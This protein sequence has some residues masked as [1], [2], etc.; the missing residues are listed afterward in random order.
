MRV[1][2]SEQQLCPCYKGRQDFQKLVEL[3]D[4]S[5]AIYCYRIHTEDVHP[6]SRQGESVECTENTSR[7]VFILQNKNDTRI[8]IS[9][10]TSKL[11]KNNISCPRCR[12]TFD[13]A[14]KLMQ[15]VKSIERNIVIGICDHC[16]KK[17]Q[18]IKNQFCSC[19]EIVRKFKTVKRGQQENIKNQ[20]KTWL[21]QMEH[22]LKRAKT[23][24][25]PKQIIDR[26][27]SDL[28]IN[29]DLKSSTSRYEPKIQ[30]MFG[31]DTHTSDINLNREMRETVLKED[32]FKQGLTY[33]R[34]TTSIK[35]V[36]PQERENMNTVISH[37]LL[38]E[39]SEDV[40][41]H[42]RTSLKED[43][44]K[45]EIFEDTPSMDAKDAL[46][47]RHD[48]SLRQMMRFENNSG[49]PLNVPK[50]SMIYESPK[51][52]LGAQLSG[53]SINIK[54]DSPSGIKVSQ[55]KIIKKNK[56]EISA[57]EKETKMKTDKR[58]ESKG[59]ETEEKRKE[60]EEKRKETEE[61][62]K[63]MGEKR[64]ETEE[65]RKET[66]ELRKKSEELG[67]KSE[68]KQKETEEK[69]KK[70]EEKRKDSE[71][72]Q[73]EIGEKRKG[74]VEKRKGSEE[75]RRISE[76]KL[77]ETEEKQKETEEKRKKAEEK[78]KKFEENLKKSEEKLKKSEEKLKVT[79]EKRKEKE[80]KLK[81]KED[82][83]RLILSENLKKEKEALKQQKPHE[84]LLQKEQL[85]K[86]KEI[87]KKQSETIHKQTEKDPEFK[88]SDALSKTKKSSDKTKQSPEVTKVSLI[89]EKIPDEK[90]IA[91][92]KQTPPEKEGKS[93]EKKLKQ[94]AEILKLQAEHLMKKVSEQKKQQQLEAKEKEKRKQKEQDE[95][96]AKK[97]SD[98]KMTDIKVIDADQKDFSKLVQF[99]QASAF[100]RPDMK[101]VVTP[102][103]TCHH[104]KGLSCP[105][106]YNYELELKPSLDSTKSEPSESTED[107][108]VG[109]KK[110]NSLDIK[111]SEPIEEMIVGE[112]ILKIK[113]RLE[114]S[115]EP[116][117]VLNIYQN[118]LLDPLDELNPQK[119][120][121]DETRKQS[122]TVIKNKITGEIDLE[123]SK[124]IL[125]YR[126]SDRTFIEKGW[127]VL[128]T[129]KVVRKLNV[130]RMRPARPEFDW[131]EHNKN[132]RQM[133][134][135]TGE[136]LAEF[137][138][139]GRGRWYYRSGR[140]AL[141]YY[142]AEETNA[143]QRFVVYS[144]GEPDER[145]RT[146]PI[147]V[148]A[149]FDYLGNGV[150]FDH[151]GKIRLK[152]NQTEGVV[153]DRSIGPVSHWK[154]HT[155]NDPPVLQQVMI[156][157]QLPQ[158]DPDILKLGQTEKT[159]DK[160]D[161]EDML[162]IEF[163]NFI[164]EKSKKLTQKFK[165]F[166]IK[167]KF[168]KINEH[169]SLKVLDQA[170]VYL[171]YR[172]GST[173]LKLN[174]GMILD[175]KEIVDTETAEV[176]EVLN[177]IEQFPAR[178]DSLAGLQRSVAHAQRYERQ[179][180]ERERRI[181]PA[182]PCASADLLTAAVSAPLR[183]PFR[184][185]PS[186]STSTT[187]HCRRKPTKN[188]YYDS[189]LL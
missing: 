30:Q 101:P 140:L 111:K 150:V 119:E 53:R 17:A 136:R 20:V 85:Q 179:H 131:F 99:K 28:Q 65:K 93:D 92:I 12:K 72:K 186:G 132:K 40:K 14:Q 47:R 29:R 63:E 142:D 23:L 31:S 125:R 181:R 78:L 86:E 57:N 164:K 4:P 27:Y 113:P 1:S 48:L 32:Y 5:L 183:V 73:K 79:E 180:A 156:D 94:E 91:K 100:N 160:P 83:E 76:E 128:P 95:M 89:Q 107:M 189:R 158:K 143:K 81:E 21:S 141:D 67:K 39:I 159:V 146:H 127:T 84:K 87:P 9:E 60:T 130:Y 68:E 188:L 114:K 139:N 123:A 133:T 38:L 77:K 51:I 163:D 168:L 25:K 49:G 108:L 74:T 161:N 97:R 56:K 42:P 13:H 105:L 62:R 37:T 149:T 66:E 147:T 19:D 184:T 16:R 110:L 45:V 52:A 18:T 122:K 50:R 126:L 178:T 148:L 175:H 15:E 138:D 116:E 134:Y 3:K 109:E 103:P 6:Q 43:R 120:P 187:G 90:E 176:G 26:A 182:A 7:D 172:D 145:G 124:G 118:F 167:M 115:K 117:V 173:N 171:I 75:K 54:R 61:K 166:Q 135:D 58:D 33:S 24:N 8:I 151:A 70:S 59:K 121:T 46:K 112:K 88:I 44:G 177:S 185:M 154:W 41:E 10:L 98:L 69:R 35:P 104:D 106:C 11:E 102:K 153:L 144:S 170:T 165:P 174:M 96:K 152:Y 137:D 34:P 129:E 2:G 36:T 22:I 80:Q 64:K 71:D 157:T 55:S 155:L 169:F 82:K 162:A